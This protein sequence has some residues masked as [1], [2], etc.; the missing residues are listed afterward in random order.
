MEENI[1]EIVEKSC[2]AW[3]DHEQTLKSYDLA[4]YKYYHG[5]I[6]N[7]LLIKLP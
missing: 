3:N 2:R 5:I 4:K 6:H 7:L 1:L